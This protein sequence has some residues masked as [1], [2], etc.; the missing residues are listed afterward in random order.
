[1]EIT[2]YELAIINGLFAVIGGLV[3]AAATLRAADRTTERQQLFIESS[4]FRAAFVDVLISLRRADKDVFL[5]ITEQVLAKQEQ[6]KVLFEPWVGS[7][8]ASDFAKAWAAYSEGIKTKAP[9]SILNRQNECS[10]SI[11]E[12]EVLLSFAARGS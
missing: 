9:G 12:I 5:V 1:M 8:C 11:R 3:G 4:R 6:A 7:R 2:A 10:T